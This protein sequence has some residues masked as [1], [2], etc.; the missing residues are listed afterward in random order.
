[1]FKNNE[2]SDKVIRRG[3]KIA[4]TLTAWFKANQQFQEASELTYA[5][6]PTYWVYNKQH[7][8]WKP[9]QK[10]NTIGR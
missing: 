10:G 9:Q 7:K 6:F 1:I 5:D 2:D 4:T 3:S 8:K